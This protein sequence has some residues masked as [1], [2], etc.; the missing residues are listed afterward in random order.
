MQSELVIGQDNVGKAL[1]FGMVVV[2]II[3]MSLHALLQ[4]RTAKWAS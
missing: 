1:A 2:V 4:R 3:V